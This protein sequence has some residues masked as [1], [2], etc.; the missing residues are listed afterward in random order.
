LLTNGAG[1]VLPVPTMAIV[2]WLTA[3]GSQQL[4]MSRIPRERN[5]NLR[6][7]SHAYVLAAVR[8]VSTG[9]QQPR[10]A[11]ASSARSKS[12]QSCGVIDQNPLALSR[13]GGPN[14]KL[15]QDATIIDG[16]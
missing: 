9:N 7:Q 12:I 5:P 13:V 4:T 16:K 3:M 14:R 1:T 8:Q 11:A 2:C 15:V 10:C 6:I